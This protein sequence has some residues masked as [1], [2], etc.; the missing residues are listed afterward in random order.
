M[1]VMTTWMYS[2]TMYLWWLIALSWPSCD[3]DAP[4]L[5]NSCGV[6]VTELFD[7]EYLLTTSNG[8]QMNIRMHLHHLLWLDDN[9]SAASCQQACCKLIVEIF[10]SQ[11]WCKL[12]STPANITLQQ[13]WLAAIWWS[14]QAWCNLLTTCS[15][16]IQSTTCSNCVYI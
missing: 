10:Y 11:A 2:T 5:T 14:Q 8:V 6:I 4:L 9:R 12:F 16:P 1:R 7:T 13:V 3:V 15:K